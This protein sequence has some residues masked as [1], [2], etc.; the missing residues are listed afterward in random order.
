MDTYAVTNDTVQFGIA[1]YPGTSVTDL[2][3]HVGE[4]S[5]RVWIMTDWATQTD[6][7][8]TMQNKV[9]LND[10]IGGGSAP[11]SDNV[12]NY[13]ILTPQTELE[14]EE[15]KIVLYNNGI[16]TEPYQFINGKWYKYTL[17]EI[18]EN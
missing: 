4:T 13:L 2:E 9:L 6:N 15:G 18:P 8:T 5:R 3:L 17:R 10:P 7:L 12:F 11:P 1:L 16:T 14:G